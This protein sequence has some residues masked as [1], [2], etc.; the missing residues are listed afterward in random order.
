MPNVPVDDML[1]H[2]RDNDL[3]VGT[4]GR[5]IWIMDDIAPLEALTPDACVAS[6][7]SSRRRGRGC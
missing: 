1:I 7:R 3:I 5:S 6:V 2:P 4:H